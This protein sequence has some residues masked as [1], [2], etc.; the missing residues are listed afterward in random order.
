MGNLKN[1]VEFLE[2]KISV[3]TARGLRSFVIINH[4]SG[5][6][7]T[8]YTGT[9]LKNGRILDEHLP[10]L[11]GVTPE[12]FEEYKSRYLEKDDTVVGVFPASKKVSQ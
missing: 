6:I 12:V 11:Q 7:D 5:G 4:I 1:R 9:M 3:Q 10:D 8:K 2:G